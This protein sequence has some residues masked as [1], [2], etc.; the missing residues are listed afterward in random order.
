MHESVELNI[1]V[2]REAKSLNSAEAVSVDFQNPKNT[3]RRRALCIGINYR[4]QRH[5]LRRCI[6]DAKH[7][8]SFLVRRAGF[9]AEEIV[10]LMDDSP[11]PRVQPTRK[12]IIDAIRW[13]AHDARPDDV[14]FFHY[15]GRSGQT[16][17]LDGDE[18]NGYDDV[19][20]PLDYLKTGH[21]VD[22][23]MHNI[24]VK[25]LPSGCR[26]TAVFDSHCFG[27]VLDLPYIYDRNGRL[28]QPSL[29]RLKLKESSGVAISLS[30]H[31]H[32]QTS[33]ETFTGGMSRAFIKAIE[34]HPH[35][36]YQEFLYNVR[37]I[38]GQEYGQK[39]RLESSHPIDMSSEFIF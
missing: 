22:H 33:T 27:T 17:D 9:K 10:V 28:K 34:M 23:E 2:K 6:D 32:G 8:F 21:I 1:M 31:K 20:Y 13:L 3:G 12:N 36:S 35:Q 26:L 29:Q 14:L 7:V 30:G 11:H 38:M 39:P 16:R 25:P 15:S 24:M 37:D 4:G 19:I 18:I 5:A